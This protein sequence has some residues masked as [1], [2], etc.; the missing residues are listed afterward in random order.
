MAATSEC[1]IETR[2]TFGLQIELTLNYTVGVHG[3]AVGPGTALQAG[4][5]RVRFPIG[6]FH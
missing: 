3:G 5:S 2:C 6:I 1:S 4:R